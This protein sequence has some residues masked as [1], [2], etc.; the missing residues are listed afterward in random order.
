[1]TQR[2]RAVQ[3]LQFCTLSVDDWE[4]FAVEITR[5]YTRG[6]DVEGTPYDPR[7]GALENKEKCVVCGEENHDCPGH[8]GYIRLEEPIFNSEY[9]D[10]AL[11]LLRC[12][13]PSCYG[14]RIL[15]DN[16]EW[17]NILKQHRSGRLKLFKKKC[18]NVMQCP[19]CQEPLPIFADN[20]GKIEMAYAKKEK[21]I[22]VSTREVLA[23]LSQITNETF[24]LLGFNQGLATNSVFTC[25]DIVLPEDKIHIHQIRPESFIFTLLPVT[26]TCSRPWV[27][28]DGEK[29]D[30]DITERYNSILKVNNKLRQDRLALSTAPTVVVRGK[31]KGAKMTDVERQKA[32]QE[33]QNHVHTLIENQDKTGAGRAKKGIR[34]RL[35]AKDGHIL[36]NAAGKR[37]DQSARSVIVGAGS[38]FPVGYV[39]M[40]ED[41]A[42]TLTVPEL[43]VEWNIEYLQKLVD[44]KRANYVIRQGNTINLNTLA[45]AGKTCRIQLGDM[46]ERHYQ[47]EDELLFNRQPTLEE[48]CTG[49]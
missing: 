47:D 34:D 29:R 44:E 41:I 35:V 45:K 46:V 23:I 10:L 43:A 4:K 49:A 19:S 3:W 5:P 6:G 28:R 1:M 2:T 42:K 37:V 38:L 25:D 18:E 31:K 40:P 17:M 16:A 22:P 32:V 12:I 13:C 39:G 48:L 9:Y 33:L 21:T 8:F 14:P 20:G 7:L 15:K 24:S 27:N 26:P 11:A 30:D 36:N